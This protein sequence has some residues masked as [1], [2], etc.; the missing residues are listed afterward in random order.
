MIHENRGFLN[1]YCVQNGH[2]FTAICIDCIQYTPRIYLKADHVHRG[3]RCV[4]ARRGARCL[5]PQ[6]KVET[7]TAIVVSANVFTLYIYSTN[8]NRLKKADFLFCLIKGKTKE[9]IY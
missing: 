2:C 8:G 1:Y 6:L 5:L 7:G 3:V 9:R 4:M